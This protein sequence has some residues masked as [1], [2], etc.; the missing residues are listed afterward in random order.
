MAS[1]SQNELEDGVPARAILKL[2]ERS[3]WRRVWIVQEVF[4]ARRLLIWCGNRVVR[5]D[6]LQNFCIKL[7][8]ALVKTPGFTEYDWLR[9]HLRP[10]RPVRLVNDRLRWRDSPRASTHDSEAINNTL[11][12]HKDAECSNIRDK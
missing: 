6:A 3:Y 2:F 4:L 8:G 5:W 11:T 12:A 10:S 9:R 7:A 1:D